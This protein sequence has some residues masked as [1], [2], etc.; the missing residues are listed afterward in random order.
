MLPKEPLP[1]WPRPDKWE[2]D[3]NYYHHAK[4]FWASLY[5]ADAEYW[6]KLSRFIIWWLLFSE[7]VR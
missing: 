7:V 1:H 3:G 5:R 2:S 4:G 6:S